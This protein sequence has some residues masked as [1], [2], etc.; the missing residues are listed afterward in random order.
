MRGHGLKSGK[1]KGVHLKFKGFIII[2][3]HTYTLFPPK[4]MTGITNSWAEIP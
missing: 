2:T 3:K 1:G 4:E